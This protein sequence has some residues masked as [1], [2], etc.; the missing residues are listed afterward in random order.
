M[1]QYYCHTCAIAINIYTPD[2]PGNLTGTAYQCGKFMKHTMPT[3]TYPGINS[4]F[5][6]PTYQTYFDYVVTG[7]YSGMLEID[8]SGHMNLIWYAGAQTGVELINGIFN[9]PTDGIKIVMIFDI[10]RIHSYPIK[11]Q[12][13]LIKFCANCGKPLPQW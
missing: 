3:G 2:Y 6:D 5:N 10:D 11:G 4:I 12:P 8:D 7:S 9:A 1:S 13:G